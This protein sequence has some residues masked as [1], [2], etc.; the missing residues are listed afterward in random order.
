[1]ERAVGLKRFQL[2]SL[3]QR[4]LHFAESMGSK[5]WLL[6]ETVSVLPKSARSWSAA[7]MITSAGLSFLRGIAIRFATLPGPVRSECYG[8]SWRRWLPGSRPQPTEAGKTI[9]R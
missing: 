6:L 1:M 9:P 2:L 7:R 8:R 3:Q 5:G 4:L